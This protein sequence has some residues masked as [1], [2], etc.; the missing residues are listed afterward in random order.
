[1]EQQR[2][3]SGDRVR[4]LLALQEIAGLGPAGIKSLLGR[5]GSVQRL[6]AAIDEPPG[7]DRLFE[8]VR[9]AIANVDWSAIDVE[10]RAAE[11]HGIAVCTLEDA[12]YPENLKPIS[13][14]PPVLWYRGT[15]KSL[16]RRA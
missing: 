14:P 2:P 10:I 6:V 3:D 4:W 5:Y 9:R 13:G 11:D 8:V 12:E 7:A 15:L 1:M 16:R